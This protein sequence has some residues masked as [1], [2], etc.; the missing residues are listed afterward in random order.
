MQ[1]SKMGKLSKISKFGAKLG[2]GKIIIGGVGGEILSFHYSPY[3]PVIIHWIIQIFFVLL[4]FFFKMINLI[5][6]SFCETLQCYPH[7]HFMEKVTEP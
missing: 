6:L 5:F 7:S 2:E 4:I 3:Q 1:K